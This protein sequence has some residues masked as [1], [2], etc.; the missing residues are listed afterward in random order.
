MLCTV[1]ALAAV[2]FNTI[3]ALVRAGAQQ[4]EPSPQIPQFRVTGPV[5]FTV[6]DPNPALR[7]AVALAMAQARAMVEGV[8]EDSG[9]KLGPILD[10]RKSPLEVT[11]PRREE[12]NIADEL[13]L[14]YSQHVERCRDDSCVLCC[15]IFN[16]IVERNTPASMG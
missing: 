14:Q 4:P 15:A 7:K 16:K 10:A 8:A 6:K 13:H 11:L 12:L 2:I 5:L 1:I 3:D 9:T